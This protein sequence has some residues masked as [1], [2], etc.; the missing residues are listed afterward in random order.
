MLSKKSK[1][2]LKALTILAKEYGQGPVLISDIARREEI[3]RKFLEI[4][5]LELKNAG[6]LQSRKGKGG[7]YSLGRPPQQIT[8]GHVIRVLDGP[9]APLPC[10]SRSAYI[11]CRECRDE[12]TCGIRMVMKQVRDATAQI[13]DSTTLEDMLKQVELAVMG[14]DA[15]SFSI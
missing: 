14:K 11:R 12:R 4:I 15:V 13:L 3:S 9:L 6:I 1:Y 2:A 10:V 7:G 8:L 5:L